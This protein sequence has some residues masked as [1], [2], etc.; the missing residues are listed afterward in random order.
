METP[1]PPTT[2]GGTTSGGQ[3]VE[4]ARETVDGIP[5]GNTEEATRVGPGAPE[6]G[7]MAQIGES[8]NPDDRLQIIATG[9]DNIQATRTDKDKSSEQREILEY[10]EKPW[11]GQEKIEK[12][13]PLPYHQITT[14][15]DIITG[16]DSNHDDCSSLFI[17]NKAGEVMAVTTI[18]I[19]SAEKLLGAQG[20]YYNVDKII[21]DVQQELARRG[22]DSA[23]GIIADDFTPEERQNPDFDEIY[24]DLEELTGGKDKDDPSYTTDWMGSGSTYVTEQ[25][26]M[27]KQPH[28]QR[29]EGVAEMTNLLADPA[30]KERFVRVQTVVEKDQIK[31]VIDES[32][33]NVEAR[34]KPL[35]EVAAAEKL[36]VA[37]V[38]EGRKL[39]KGWGEALRS[40][41][42]VRSET[43]ELIPIEDT[44]GEPGGEPKKGAKSLIKNQIRPE[45]EAKMAQAQQNL[46]EAEARQKQVL[47]TLAQEL[48]AHSEDPA[49]LDAMDVWGRSPDARGNRGARGQ[50]LHAGVEHYI[51]YRD[52]QGKN[53]RYKDIEPVPSIDGFIQYS[54][55]LKGI[56]NNP[57]PAVNPD[58]QQAALIG[59]EEG[60]R[61]LYALGKTGELIVGFQKPGEEA[62]RVVTVIPGQAE[63]NFQKA[64]QDEANNVRLSTSRLNELGE[65]KKILQNSL[66]PA[67]S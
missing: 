29:E 67:S 59:D 64:V 46:Q 57:N 9:T 1:L 24:V 25:D 10:Q 4:G 35:I 31:G 53:G 56:V 43:G 33:K 27:L 41:A 13:E 11:P 8:G 37:T 58:V 7:I 42:E 63:K 61:R 30:F 36:G 20:E 48:K 32:K 17:M 51:E 5:G 47:A 66:S 40:V 3:E 15:K 65:Q 38:E 14:P 45:L 6:L 34:L 55:R 21:N 62:M 39:G 18:G 26:E 60:Q 12:G 44:P 2:P 52:D 23:Y 28:N 16:R 49:L 50:G 54:N 22:L 19:F